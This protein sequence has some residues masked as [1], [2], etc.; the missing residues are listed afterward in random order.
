VVQQRRPDPNTT[1]QASKY[2]GVGLTSAL[3]TLLFLYLGTI[4]DRRLGT[5]PW[6]TLAGA[7]VG[8]AAGF[9]HM[10]YHLVIVP[11]NRG[12]PDDRADR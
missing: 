12:R 8:A 3:S 2:L 11:R 10:Y 6:L 5:G 9:F 1:A 7:F 4:A